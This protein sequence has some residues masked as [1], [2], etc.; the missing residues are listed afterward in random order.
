MHQKIVF[1]VHLF[2]KQNYLQLSYKIVFHF[3]Y[4][5]TFVNHYGH[6]FYKCESFVDLPRIDTTEF[7]VEPLRT[8]EA[9]RSRTYHGS[10]RLHLLKLVV[11]I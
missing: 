11:N 4:S 7:E 2:K 5:Y 6:S 10:G 1:Q 8:Y 3:N 9:E